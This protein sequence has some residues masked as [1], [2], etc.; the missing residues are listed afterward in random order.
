VPVRAHADQPDDQQHRRKASVREAQGTAIR[1]HTAQGTRMLA[2]QLG[3]AQQGWPA[4]GWRVRD[5]T[6]HVCCPFSTLTP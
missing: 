3:R 4:P 1:T 2:R 5:T 6:R